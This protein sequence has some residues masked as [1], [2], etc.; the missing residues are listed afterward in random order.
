MSETIDLN[1]RAVLR[2]GALVLGFTLL[3][4]HALAEFNGM[5]VPPISNKDL[6]GSL[7]RTP[8]LDAWIRIAADGKVTVFTGKVELGTGVRTALLQVA[9]EQLDVAPAAINFITADTALTPNEGFTAG[10]HTMA[11]SGTALLNA[12][13]QVRAGAA[14]R[15]SAAQGRRGAAHHQQRH[16]Q[17]RRRPPAALRRA[18][19]A[20]TCIR[21]RKPGRR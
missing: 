20:S 21:P 6:A 7:Q 1:R 18:V 16:R 8:M 3:P 4:R 5:G 17:R 19:R 13:A 14:R 2:G 9:A 12:A 11:D 10:S 15:G